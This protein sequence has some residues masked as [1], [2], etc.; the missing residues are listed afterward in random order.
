MVEVKTKDGLRL[1]NISLKNRMK[2]YWFRC[3]PTSPFIQE[4]SWRLEANMWPVTDDPLMGSPRA[5][6]GTGKADGILASFVFLFLSFLFPLFFVCFF[7]F[8]LAFFFHVLFLFDSS[9]FWLF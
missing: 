9:C 1:V 5:H 4:L 6:D 3:T 7:C 2:H 8:V